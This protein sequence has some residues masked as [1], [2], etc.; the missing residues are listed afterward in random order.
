MKGPDARAEGADFF[1]N[2]ARFGVGH[3]Q[4]GRLNGSKIGV[5]ADGMNQG[6]VHAAILNFDESENLAAIGIE[7]APF[8]AN[9]G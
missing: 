6:I 5:I 1:D 4:K 2:F 7:N 9:T 8:A 3:S